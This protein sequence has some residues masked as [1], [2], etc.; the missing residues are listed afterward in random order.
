[1]ILISKWQEIVTAIETDFREG[2]MS[3]KE[4]QRRLHELF[5]MET[6]TQMW[7]ALYSARKHDKWE[8]P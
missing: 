5:D 7:S 3:D 6:A 1:M 4:T 8:K 2:N